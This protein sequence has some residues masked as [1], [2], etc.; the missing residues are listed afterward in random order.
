VAMTSAIRAFKSESKMPLNTQL[1]EVMVSIADRALISDSVDDMLSPMA[2][3]SIKFVD[4]AGMQEVVVGVKPN[5]AKIGPHFK[6]DAKFIF[7][8]IKEIDPLVAWE[9]ANGDGFFV[10]IPGKGE[11]EVPKDFMVFEQAMTLSGKR[12]ATINIPEH[13]I[14]LF[15]E[16]K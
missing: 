5:F 6:G 1:G 10:N 9:K 16:K 7:Q 15:V 3:D 4:K 13:D 11:V 8:A 2:A 14:T 12:V